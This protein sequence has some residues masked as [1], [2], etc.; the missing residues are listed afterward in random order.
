MD[1]LL[2]PKLQL[3]IQI[4]HICGPEVDVVATLSRSQ[5]S[6]VEQE[7][8]LW[9]MKLAGVKTSRWTTGRVNY[10][11]L[12]KLRMKHVLFYVVLTM[13]SYECLY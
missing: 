4:N 13:M 10:V 6:L 9:P 7:S 8:F 11:T 2:K 1:I 5:R 12:E 3:C